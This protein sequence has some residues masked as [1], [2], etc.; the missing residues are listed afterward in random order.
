MAYN[1]PPTWDPGF[2]MPQNALDEGLER[3]AFVTKQLPAGTYD[4]VRTG[5]GGY[6]VPQYVLDE[7]TGRGTF[8]TKELPGGV[9]IGPK[10]PHWLNQRP[11]IATQSRK[12]DTL[13]TKFSARSLQGLGGIS[14]AEATLHPVFGNYGARAAR[15]LMSQAM[16]RP[17][18]QRRAFLKGVLDR[19]DP[20]IWG[21]AAEY[22]RQFNRQGMPT[23]AA[24]E[25]GIAQAMGAGLAKEIVDTGLRGSVKRK[26][27]LGLG[28]FGSFGALGDVTP[29]GAG[30]SSSVACPTGSGNP[31]PGYTWSTVGGGHWA[32]LTVGQVPVPNPIDGCYTLTSVTHPTGSQPATGGLAASTVPM[33]QV[34]PFQVP[35]DATS[36][37]MGATVR[38]SRTNQP[39]WTGATTPEWQKGIGEEI[40]RL[41]QFAVTRG[42][43]SNTYSA[44]RL[45]PA[46]D[47]GLIVPPLLSPVANGVSPAEV[48]AIDPTKIPNIAGTAAPQDLANFRQPGW[49]PLGFFPTTINGTHATPLYRAKHPITGKDYGVFLQQG[50][51]TGGGWPPAGNSGGFPPDASLRLDTNS[52]GKFLHIGGPLRYLWREVVPLEKSALGNLWDLIQEIVVAVIHAAE[53]VL[54][55]IGGFACD[56]LGN[57]I[58]GPAAAV[59]AVAGGAPPAAGANGVAI[60]KNLCGKTPPP[61]V[62][63][64]SS[65]LPVALIAGGV[66]LITA[67]LTHTKKRKVSP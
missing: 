5:T 58:A 52:D 8:T 66:L 40:V 22:A 64:G 60:A 35:A 38:D 17:Q 4:D 37:M 11:Q 43:F 50:P 9:Y 3:R 53:A 31:V 51:I 27:L 1:L 30:T 47:V 55:T 39:V 54:T 29:S 19:V 41:W 63:G 21:R 14:G 16:A 2:A 15:L 65:I 57:P 25:R 13:R 24:V 26:S 12:G 48:A 6:V 44:N 34:G 59:T 45:V 18:P 20:T 28:C 61:M 56:V 33:L 32:R 10:I 67:V 36:F 46:S 49:I 42:L 7:R 23:S 62:S